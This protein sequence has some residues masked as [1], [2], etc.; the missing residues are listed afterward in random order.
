MDEFLKYI[1]DKKFIRWVLQPDEKN[2]LYWKNYLKDHP[3]EKNELEL[4]RLIVSQLKSKTPHQFDTEVLELYAGIVR[5]LDQKKKSMRQ[6]QLWISISKYAAVALIFL[7][8]GVLFFSKSGKHDFPEISQQLAISQRTNESQLIL[9]DG[10]IINISEKNSKIRYSSK[11]GIIINE[12]DTIRQQQAGESSMNQ[13]IV[14]YGR[15]SSVQL[16]DG[17]I[18]WLNAGSRL[19][20]PSVFEGKTREVFLVGEGFFKVAHNPDMPFFVK[21]NDINVEAIGTSFNVSAYPVDRNIEVVLVEGKVGVKENAMRILKKP[22]ILEPNQMATFNRETLETSVERV[23]V[24]NFISW[25]QGYLNFE[26]IGLNQI[27]VKLERY[28]DIK[29]QLKDPSFGS[30]KIT[31]KMKL[32]GECEDVLKNLASTADL[33]LMKENDRNYVLK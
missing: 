20:Y 19:I 7:S 21:T 3:E 8:I 27:V 4:A 26:S 23:S 32:K 14:P 24:E 16:P 12:A 25:Y 1:D 28:Y 2:D 11:N 18:A 13:L 6:R 5:K 29:I 17:T 31:G 15:N 30:R 22:Y 9:G 10:E 33:K